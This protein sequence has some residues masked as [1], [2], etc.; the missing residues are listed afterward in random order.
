MNSYTERFYGSDIGVPKQYEKNSLPKEQKFNYL[1]LPI[2]L[3]WRH[4]KMLTLYKASN[5]LT[6]SSS[7]GFLSDDF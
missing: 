6:V 7:S 4:V 5:F 2:W 1:G 3:L